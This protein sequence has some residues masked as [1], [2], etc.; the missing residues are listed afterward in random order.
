MIMHLL[1]KLREYNKISLQE[2]LLI[3][4]SLCFGIILVVSFDLYITFKDFKKEHALL[5]ENEFLENL[6]IPDKYL[7]WKPKKNTIAI[8]K[9]KGD[10]DVNYNIDSLSFKWINNNDGCRRSIYFFGDSFT[11]GH[12]VKNIDTFPNII[13]SNYLKNSFCVYNAGVMGYGFVNMYQ[14]FLNIQEMI[15]EDDVV[16]FATLSIDI[17]RNI[18]NFK[19]QL[20]LVLTEKKL[21]YYPIYKNGK[22]LPFRINTYSNILKQLFIN[23]HFGAIYRK[24]L[25]GV[26]SEQ[27]IDD[28]LNIVKII[29]K[30][31]LKIEEQSLF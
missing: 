5:T 6:H 11:F 29:K 22:I 7:S 12:G 21:Q 26:S 2:Y 30:K 9:K 17:T 19:Q 31:K 16:V 4:F 10:Y 27:L 20:V 25:S 24:I 18:N 23:S 28:S 3:A 8:H 13:K 15:K 14:R 1:V